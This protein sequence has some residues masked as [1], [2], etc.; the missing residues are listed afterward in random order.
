MAN[1][2]STQIPIANPTNG[3]T[4]AM[5]TITSRGAR[6]TFFHSPGP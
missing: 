3:L 2:K 4:L 1:V 6:A 5:S